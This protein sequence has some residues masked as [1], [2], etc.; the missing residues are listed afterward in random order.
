MT[1]DQSS[2]SDHPS[3][4]W[5]YSEGADTRIGP[6]TFDQLLAE[7]QSGKISPDTKVWKPGLANWQ[8]AKDIE[9]LFTPPT[10]TTKDIH[11][12]LKYEDLSGGNLVAVNTTADA[13][14]SSDSIDAKSNR[15]VSYFARHWRGECSLVR[16]YWIN[17]VLIS[18]GASFA[19]LFLSSLIQEVF[20]GDFSP[21][22]WAFFI[23]TL[24]GS[25]LILGVWQTVGL[26][27]SATNYQKT[28]NKPWGGLAK[29]ACVL[30][31]VR[32]VVEISNAVFPQA[33]ELLSIVQGD[34]SLGDYKI[35]IA[36][37]GNAIR[38]TGAIV[39][40]SAKRFSEALERA[41]NVKAVIINSNGGR[42]AVASEMRKTIVARR[43]I[44]YT[45]EN[46]ESACMIAFLGGMERYAHQSAKVGF[47][48][49]AFPGVSASDLKDVIASIRLEMRNSGVSDVL[50]NAFLATPNS[51]MHYP[52]ELE[53][54]KFGVIKDTADS[55]AI[56]I[57]G[58]DFS[59]HNVR[60]ALLKIDSYLALNSVDSAAVDRSVA[61]VIR[62]RL[63]GADR[64]A[65]YFS[66]KPEILAAFSKALPR[67][68]DELLLE[69]GKLLVDQL[70]FLNNLDPKLCVAYLREGDPLAQRAT[71][72]LSADLLKR[73]LQITSI[74]IKESQ[75]NR[76][77]QL[78]EKQA[79]ALLRD[80]FV[81]LQ[82]RIG[83]GAAYIQR[84][85]DPAAEPGRLCNS[86]LELYRE[87]LSLPKS[88]AASTIR[89]LLNTR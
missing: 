80:V 83:D 54:I 57:T 58:G 52:K 55:L 79:D 29:F 37:N 6:L 78:S 62:A 73:D 36:E 44:T 67:A 26:W 35:E 40:G 32:T 88:V 20:T 18:F 63:Q 89:T 60:S 43:M 81:R 21:I 50:V 5:F 72:A 28:S 8:N 69:F 51:E 65:S 9:G 87:A 25:I 7:I 76:T 77:S 42:I 27:R 13:K 14:T 39:F 71:T 4:R 53:L 86:V 41:P 45:S 15:S 24:Y 74:V 84:I 31:V 19:T 12:S 34:K 48:Q 11:K 47:H 30:G 10:L 64:T 2:S 33:G 66:A 56:A 16:A 75:A 17:G 61:K 46:C 38:Y 70:M 23:F 68:R 82:K 85:N 3:D 59:P 22:P 49:P 1:L